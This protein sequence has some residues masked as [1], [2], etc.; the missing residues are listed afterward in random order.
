MPSTVNV[1]EHFRF[2]TVEGRVTAKV[3]RE[4]L[5]RLITGMDRKIFLMVDG[6][7]T[8][9]AKLVRASLE[10]NLDRIKLLILTPYSPE[11]KSDELAWAH[12]KT[13]VAK[14]TAQTKEES[15][16]APEQTLHQLQK[17]PDIYSGFFRTPIC[18]YANV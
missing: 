18:L 2:M 5:K 1:L 11:L 7:P 14:R 6:H 16:A 3:F 17:M 15:K 4:F 12:V 13:W 10:A 8:Y 9:N